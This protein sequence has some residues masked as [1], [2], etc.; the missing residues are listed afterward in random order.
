MSITSHRCENGLVSKRWKCHSIF[1][2]EE[3]KH[4]KW[5]RRGLETQNRVPAWQ[6]KQ[7]L[8]YYCC[9]CA[10]EAETA[11]KQHAMKY[12]NTIALWKVQ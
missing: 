3:K 1:M 8:I 5:A 10:E 6:G 2:M 11:G 7:H 12:S 9:A 4:S